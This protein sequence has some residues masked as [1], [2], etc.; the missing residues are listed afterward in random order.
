M[1]V[2]PQNIPAPIISAAVII[3]AVVAGV[4]VGFAGLLVWG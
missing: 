3:A 1:G 4:A 2:A